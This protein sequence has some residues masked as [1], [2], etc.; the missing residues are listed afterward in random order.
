MRPRPPLRA[1]ALAFSLLAAGCGPV[2]AH[3]LPGSV[4]TLWQEEAQLDLSVILPL[5]E[6]IVAAP[7]F[8]D[9][10]GLPPGQDLFPENIER[11]AA[12]F[13]DHLELRKDAAD[14]PLTVMR[15]TIGTDENSHVGTYKT[16]NVR[17]ASPLPAP[18]AALPL[19]LVYDAVMHEVRNHR[20]SVY[21][22]QPGTDSREVAE[23]GFQAADGTPRSVLLPAP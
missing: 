17:F 15:A 19:T 13:A 21:W 9:L 4:L 6:L 1:I 23:F 8:R 12:Y 10:D 5:E 20:A 7:E 2:L 22:G 16:L 3:S 11:V 14:L 18:D